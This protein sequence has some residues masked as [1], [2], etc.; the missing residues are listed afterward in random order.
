[1]SPAAATVDVHCPVTFNS[2]SSLQNSK[3]QNPNYDHQER[4]IKPPIFGNPSE[5][6]ANDAPTGTRTGPRPRPR[7]VKLRK[8]LNGRSR[9]VSGEFGSEFNPFKLGVQSC[10]VDSDYKNS[11]NGF[12]AE[13]FK[14]KNDAG[15]V[16]GATSSSSSS[17][18]SSGS[19]LNFTGNENLDSGKRVFDL[20]VEALS[21]V[22]SE[23]LGFVFEDEKK[24][25]NVKKNE[26]ASGLEVESEK[27]YSA[28]SVF[29]AKERDSSEKSED[30]RLD[31]GFHFTGEVNLDAEVKHGKD[32]F[33][34]FEF[35]ADKRCAGSDFNFEKE[36][37]GIAARL[38][39]NNGGFLFGAS[40][41]DSRKDMGVSDSGF[42]FGAN[43]FSPDDKESGESLKTSGDSETRKLY[44][45]GDITSGVNADALKFDINR[46]GNWKEDNDKVPCAFATISGESCCSGEC[47]AKDR[48]DEVKSSNEPFVSYNNSPEVQTNKESIIDP[49][50]NLYDEMKNLNIH[51]FKNVGADE[52]KKSST[53]GD[54]LFVFRSVES[55]RPC[56][57]GISGPDSQEN[58]RISEAPSKVWAGK[59]S[60]KSNSA[61]ISEGLEVPFTDF[62]SPKWDPSSLKASLFPELNKKTEFS[63]KGR[64]KKGKKSKMMTGKLK[65]S[66]QHKQHQEQH[67]VENETSASDALNS[68]GCYSPMD[69]SPYEETVDRGD[70][71]NPESSEH[72]F[73][74]CSVGDTPGKVFGFKMSYS[75][76]YTG[77]VFGS[78][79]AG[80]TSEDAFTLSSE[81]SHEIPFGFASG[82]EEIHGRE[83]SFSASSSSPKTSP[84]SASA[85]K[86]VYRKKIRRKVVGE[87]FVAAAK[88]HAKG[89]EGDLSASQGTFRN[90]AEA[91]DQVKQGSTSSPNPIQE[92]C[93]TWRL[94]GNQSYK[95]GDLSK[96]EDF[97]TRGINSVPPSEALGSCLKPLVICY[98]NRAA[99]RM[100]LGNL[101]EALKDCAMAAALD[102]RFL[103]VQMRAANCHLSLG[104][105]EKAQKYYNKCLESGT[106][107][108]LDRRITVEAADGLQKCQKVAEHMDQSAKLLDKRT[109]DAASS[110]LDLIAEALS[111]SPY[112]ESLLEMKAESMFVLHRFEEAIQLCEQTLH[113]A[114]KNFTSSSSDDQSVNKD[115]PQTGS[116]SFARMWRLRLISKSYFYMGKLEVALDLLEK[117]EQM[118]SMPD[119]YA[120]KILES[121]ISL[122]VTI[123]AL[124]HYKSAGNE[125]VQSGRYTEALEHYTAAISSNI[126]SR[127]FAAI[128]FCNRAAAHQALNQIADAIADCSLAIA[129]DGNYSKAVSRRATLHEM[130]RDYGQAASDLQRLI[131]IL[132]NT[133]EGKSRQSG[134]PSKSASKTKELRQAQ[135]RLSS[136]EEDAKKAIPLDLYHIL[137]VKQ[138]DT[139]ADIKKAYRKA[140]LRHHPDK[141]GQFL[142]RSE[143]R[144]EGRLWKD[145]V[146]EVHMDA[147]RLFKMIG[148][149][150]AVLSDPTKRAE[151]DLD[152]EIRKA[153]GDHPPR[154]PSD[155]YSYSYQRNDHGRN[156]Q[157]TW[158][159]YGHSR[160]RW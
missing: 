158:R 130:I 68:L 151:Y 8:Q 31:S 117:L 66:S 21:N 89:Q 10:S 129:L 46:T 72:H 156:W 147:D 91:K 38:D 80:V 120:C 44:V 64:S 153:D 33:A 82:L 18:K 47:L 87:R 69:F 74:K 16:F 50:I 155:G 157:D 102:P 1:M 19:V 6:N 131:S 150:Y 105:T 5:F 61:S 100:S 4:P 135:R 128:C 107:V 49:D 112:S 139:V 26:G 134:T 42:A 109:S 126:E 159:T 55:D 45:E 140:A 138:S 103:K 22:E 95:A 94:R 111:I 2:S 56:T 58:V 60:I 63:I 83:F 79:G 39:S 71:Q 70:Q 133:P 115:G 35:R 40:K 96:A 85:I 137:G 141:A 14:L 144:D 124:L 123:R 73:G 30:C 121:S 9:G 152:E 54:P 110:A 48:D 34:G 23:N 142:A 17:G 59:D 149:A 53:D 27:L 32:Y 11:E 20:N 116:Y 43:W 118:G 12:V 76:S 28:G 104:E 146:Q 145:I 108:C 148:E 81:K 51:G 99:S 97:Y 41:I 154:R 92:A 65:Q 24:K 93:E 84:K 98:S 114:E 78:N 52:S 127:P 37:S 160:S 3:N 62:E 86:R 119:K 67:Q 57:N 101:R 77:Q 90:N 136:M 113:A 29:G 36:S 143:S 75:G 125:A 132:E 13:N 88:P 15:F 106:G 122:A 7:M 25:E